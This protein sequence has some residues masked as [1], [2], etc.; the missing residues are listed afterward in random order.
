[1]CYIKYLTLLRFRYVSASYTSLVKPKSDIFNTLFEAT[2]TFLAAKSLCTNY[3]EV[4]NDNHHH[5]YIQLL[6]SFVSIIKISD[7]IDACTSVFYIA[8]SFN[9]KQ[10]Y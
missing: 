9:Q 4:I 6:F 2:K 8:E 5:V 1:M 10:T 3:N 7:R